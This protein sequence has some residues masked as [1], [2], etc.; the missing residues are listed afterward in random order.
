MGKQ[1]YSAAYLPSDDGQ[2][3]ANQGCPQAV[4]YMT[5]QWCYT[6][7]FESVC[8]MLRPGDRLVTGHFGPKTLRYQD[9]SPPVPKFTRTHQ[10]MR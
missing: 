10:E 1:Y 8:R 2:R 7:D 3:T 9:A 4:A 5:F 6:N